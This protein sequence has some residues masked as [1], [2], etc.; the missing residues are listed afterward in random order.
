MGAENT[1]GKSR[2]KGK[3]TFRPQ[4]NLTSFLQTAAWVGLM[5]FQPKNLSI[6]K[7]I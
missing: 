2:K 7:S 4:Y 6:E 3:V 5:L 1:R